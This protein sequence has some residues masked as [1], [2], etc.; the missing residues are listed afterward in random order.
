MKLYELT[1]TTDSFLSP[2]E[3]ISL[4]EKVISLLQSQPIHQSS[5]GALASLDFYSE[6]EKIKEI[7]E[8]L[9][10][11]KEINHF[12]L[13]KKSLSKPKLR[14]SKRVAFVPKTEK[15]PE[16]SKVELKKIEEKLDELLNE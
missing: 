4:S 12:M 8:K 7:E 15:K 9:R 13:I 10:I 2:E 16:K 5:S 6:P 11:E 14:T 3:K 1:Y